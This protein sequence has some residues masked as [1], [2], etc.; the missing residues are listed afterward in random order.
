[1]SLWIGLYLHR[2]SLDVWR[3]RWLTEPGRAALVLDKGVV[4]AATPAAV[5]LGVAIG[6]RQSS[7]CGLAPD[8]LVLTRDEAA[9]Q[10]ALDLAA[11]A[12]LRYTPSVAQHLQDTILLEVAAS[13]RLFGG[14]RALM[15]LLRRDLHHLHIQARCSMAPTAH[16]AWLLAQ[17]GGALRYS[18]RPRS[19][20]RALDRLPCAALPEARPHL[21][22]LGAVGCRTLGQ[23][24]G[25]PRAG[26]GRRSSPTLLGA[27]SQ[28]YEGQALRYTPYVA[29]DQFLRHLD[30]QDRIEQ[31]EIILA[32]VERLMQS[33]CVWLTARRQAARGIGVDLHHERGR[34]ARP[35]TTIVM[36]LAEPGWIIAHFMDPLRERLT[37][38]TLAEP[39]VAITLRCE[40]L[41]DFAPDSGLLFPDPRNAPA[42]YRRLLDLLT[43]RLGPGQI[44]RPH[45]VADHRPEVA[46]AWVHAAPAHAS[47]ATV[48]QATRSA[49]SAGRATST[50]A[51]QG[52]NETSA[53]SFGPAA[54]AERPFWM[55][56][57][58][59]ALVMHGDRPVLGS[60]L[61]L[62]RG[63]ERIESGWWDGHFAV[64]DYFVA[65]DQQAVRYW[66][67]RERDAD[68]ARWFL[69]G[70]FG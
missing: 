32:I 55:L 69:H 5:H 64:R 1:M 65:Q 67:Y 44:L 48:V 27:L 18:V 35:P 7:A 2:L 38:Q 25:L 45:P 36:A 6:M 41:A 54:R 14:I 33:L 46:N 21:D 43:A 30:L 40:S 47:G 68:P 66:I 42:E 8:A 24:R 28:A 51:A 34:R 26:L 22:W 58:P 10:S 53:A 19:L 49:Q 31:A 56:P 29:P 11:Q 37:R 57:E 16:G 9:E 62:V 17:A 61:Q 59:R 50:A 13:L 52:Q 15:Q 3:L 20:A 12:A 70:I 23:L 4:I 39:V 63:P 60:A